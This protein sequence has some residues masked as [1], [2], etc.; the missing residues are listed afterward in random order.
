MKHEDIARAF[1]G[2]R[3]DDAFGH[4]ADDVRWIIVGQRTLG[5]AEAVIEPAAALQLETVDTPALSWKRPT[6]STA[7]TSSPGDAH[8]P[9]P[10]G[11]RLCQVRRDNAVLGQ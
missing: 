8:E 9:E 4:L 5:G 2:H 6:A 11:S 7:T 10:R 3:F 1:S